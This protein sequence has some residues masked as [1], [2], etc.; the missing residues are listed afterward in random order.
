MQQRVP[1][2]VVQMM[3]RPLAVG[4]EAA[5]GESATRLEAWAAE[6]QRLGPP[7]AVPAVAAALPE[8]ERTA[9]EERGRQ[10]AQLLQQLDAVNARP[11]VFDEG[12][13]DA[14]FAMVLEERLLRRKLGGK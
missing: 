2:E 11:S 13:L 10:A 12:S 7:A 3:E 6:L 14:I 1:E 8:E 5:R 9:R 4:D